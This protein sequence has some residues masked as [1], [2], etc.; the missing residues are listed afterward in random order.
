MK[1]YE[2]STR[3]TEYYAA[4][5]GVENSMERTGRMELVRYEL[6]LADAMIADAI[7]M[8]NTMLVTIGNVACRSDDKGRADAMAALHRLREATSVDEIETVVVNQLEELN[9]SDEHGWNDIITR[10]LHNED[11][12]PWDRTKETVAP[13]WLLPFMEQAS[14][15]HFLRLP[16]D[17]KEEAARL[18]AK[19]KD[20]FPPAPDR[21]KLTAAVALIEKAKNTNDLTEIVHNVLRD[22]GM[23]DL[24]HLD[25]DTLASKLRALGKPGTVWIDAMI[26]EAVDR[27]NWLE[28]ERIQRNAVFRAL[29]DAPNTDSLIDMVNA[30][31]ERY[32]LESLK[33]QDWSEIYS[34]V[35]NTV[36]HTPNEDGVPEWLPEY[37]ERANV[38]WDVLCEEGKLS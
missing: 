20:S 11:L 28:N 13:W 15:K 14:A 21:D 32:G 22:N 1:S 7:R 33:G 8:A 19:M 9:I 2:L 26:Q 34:V 35:V 10:L 37:I 30:K 27:W 38:K 3:I 17:A 31:L 12:T 16:V 5:I 18:E 36:F 25:W 23:A 24:I 6:D 4:R 29:Q